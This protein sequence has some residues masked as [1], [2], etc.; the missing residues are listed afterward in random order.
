MDN[1]ISAALSETD[2]AAALAC[3][4]N[5]ITLLAFVRN[6]TPEEKGRIINA[7][8][9]RL[10]FSQQ[11]CQYAQ[12]FPTVLPGNFAL[13][14]FVKDINFLSAFAAVV[15]ADENFHQKVV[16]TFTLANSDAYG[17]ALKVYDFFKAANFNGEYNDVVN[18]LGA[19]FKGQGAP[20]AAAKAAKRAAQKL[21]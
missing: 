14:E 2:K 1:K 12:Q 3:F 11:A 6:I 7:A 21:A 17:Q 9:G 13:P 19:Y 4:Q 10:P 15:N 5:L 20:A 16:D 8:N 18:N